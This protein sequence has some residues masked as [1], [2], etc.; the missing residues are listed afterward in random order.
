M[1]KRFACVVL[2]A[3]L[4]GLVVGVQAATV[5]NQGESVTVTLMSETANAGT[6]DK[7]PSVEPQ[8][9]TDRRGLYVIHY[10]V[11]AAGLAAGNHDL[12]DWNI[13]KGTILL[14]DAVIE[15]QTAIAPATST[16]ALAVGGVTILATGTTLNSTGIDAA[17]S[18]PGITTA[19]D[20]PY[21]TV[22]NATATSGVFTIY[23]PVV[24]GNAQ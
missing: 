12:T 14:E 24:L 15:V 18:S 10:E 22:E 5:T 9:G 21:I 20:K 4:V 17:V 3:L 6:V 16:N 13:P 1:M 2:A 19:D 23:L 11:P 8:A 7:N